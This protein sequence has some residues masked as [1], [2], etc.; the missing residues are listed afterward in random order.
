MTTTPRKLSERYELGE[1]LGFG[2]MSEVHLA[3]DIRLSRD[4]A[5]KVLRQDLARDPTFYERFKREA[6]NAA[7]LNHPAIVAVYDT[8]EAETPEGPLP[9]I[10]MEYVEGDTLRDIVR[11]EGPMPLRRAMEVIADVCSALD[12]S[13]RNGIIHRD[14]KPANIMINRAGAVKVMDFGIAR[15]IADAANPMTQTSAVIGTAQ[16]LSPEQAQAIG[17]DARSDVYSLGC[18]LFEILTGRPPFVGDSPIAVAYQHVREEPPVPST[19]NPNIT[20]ELDSVIL[21]AL[22]KNPDN[23]YQSAAEMRSDLVRVLGGQRPTAPAVLPEEDRTDLI[24]ASGAAAPPPPPAGRRN[25]PREVSSGPG[26]HHADRPRVGS[27]RWI[28]RSLLALLLVAVVGGIGVWLWQQQSSGGGGAQQIAVPDVVAQPAET[29]RAQLTAAGLN[30]DITQKPDPQIAAGSVI[31]TRPLAG[32]S[33]DPGTTVSID[34]STGPAQVSVPDLSGMSRSAAESELTDVGLTLA[35][36]VDTTAS[37]LGQRD[38]VIRQTPAAG[39]AVNPGSAVRI[40]LGSGPEEKVVPDVSNQALGAARRTLEDAGFRV[41]IEQ[42]SSSR[43]VDQVISTN[44]AGGSD[45]VDGDTI[46]IRVSLGDLFTVP[47]LTGMTVEQAA[48][49]LNSA[50]WTGTESQIGQTTT[51]VLTPDQNG[52]VSQQSIGAGTEQRKDVGIS[53]TVGSFILGG[54]PQ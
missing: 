18:V 2:G 7:A 35:P 27:G 34:V 37:S 23:R 52:I 9:Y 13:H 6:Q 36:Q 17:V 19:V 38:Q 40:V 42:V 45:A 28:G 30:Y 21:E 51:T 14:I 32:A 53:L 11:G 48:A 43:P 10:V 8:G 24:N 1:T 25:G 12:F 47:S 41:Q 49:A 3:R 39:S 20:T 5:I 46:V 54:I 15:A 26:R 29:A 44:P 22:S 4:V 33:V 50:G 31:A 16:Y